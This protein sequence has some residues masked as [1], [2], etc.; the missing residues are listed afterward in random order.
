MDNA[1][2]HRLGPHCARIF[3]AHRLAG[4][5]QCRRHGGRYHI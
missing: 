1:G 4:R 2:R 3:E 5:C